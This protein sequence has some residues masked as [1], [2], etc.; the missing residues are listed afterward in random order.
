MSEAQQAIAQRFPHAGHIAKNVG[1]PDG[2]P[3]RYFVRNASI[4]L[5]NLPYGGIMNLSIEKRAW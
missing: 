2:G 1:A 5:A 3:L 4:M